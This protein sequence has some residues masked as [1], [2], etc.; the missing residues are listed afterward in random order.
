MI[1][2]LSFLGWEWVPWEEF[3]PLDQLFWALRCLKEQG[4]NPFKEDFDHLAGYKGYH[5]WGKKKI[6]WFILRRQN[7]ALLENEKYLHFRTIPF[8]LKSSLWLSVYLLSLNIP[9]T[10]SASTWEK[11]SGIMSWIALQTHCD[12][13]WYCGNSAFCSFRWY[14]LCSLSLPACMEWRAIEFALVFPFK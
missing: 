7:K 1:W 14:L 2:Y 12:K 10:L 13:W 6:T 8:Y 9:T 3:P 4:Y 5:P 11:F